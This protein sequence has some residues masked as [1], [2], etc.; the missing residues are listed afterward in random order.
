M[1]DKRRHFNLWKREKLVELLIE[2]ET[3]LEELQKR[4]DWE[5]KSAAQ[6]HAKLMEFTSAN[7][8]YRKQVNLLAERLG[9]KESNADFNNSLVM[10]S[11]DRLAAIAAKVTEEDRENHE[12]Q[13]EWTRGQTSLDHAFMKHEHEFSVKGLKL[14]AK[15]EKSK[16]KAEMAKAEVDIFKYQYESESA[17]AKCRRDRWIVLYTSRT[18]QTGLRWIVGAATIISGAYLY[19]NI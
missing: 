16:T 11:D 4:L 14:E 7:L 17:K 9:Q 2:K 1:D 12:Y 13:M 8:E 3:S 10:D 5:T 19:L 6:M 18:V 15:L